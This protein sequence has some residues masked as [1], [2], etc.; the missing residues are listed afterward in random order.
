MP[1]VKQANA[2]EKPVDPS[3]DARNRRLRC[4]ACGREQAADAPAMPAGPAHPFDLVRCRFC[5]LVQ[6]H[7]R[8]SP[9]EIAALYGEDYY[10]FSEAEQH[11]WAR[12]TQQY[13]VHLLRFEPAGKRRLL[14]VGCAMGHL[15]ALAAERGWRVTGFD[16]S[17]SAVSQAQKRFNLDFRAGSL[18][19]LA[20]SL[21]PTD[22]VFLGD[23]IE[24]VL[25]PAA[26]LWQ[27]RRRLVSGGC[28]CIDTPIWGGRWRRF[29]GRHWSGL[30]RYHVNLFD[31]K[32]LGSLLEAGGFANIEMAAYTHHRYQSWADRPEI[33]AWVSKL[34]AALG[35]RIN[36]LLATIGA[37]GPWRELRSNP[38]TTLTE[39]TACV[40]RLATTAGASID[41]ASKADSLVA[42]ARR[43]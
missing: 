34:P 10:V 13:L 29:G 16:L 11:R 37:G 40:D 36:R 5:G 7:P 15:S 19:R 21:P 43:T 4:V 42:W 20:E 1:R 2:S 39:A 38:P 6:Q 24:H 35:W 23:V 31:A 33:Q 26:F 22:V 12:A 14:D 30:N 27:V 18:Q 8:Y 32:S 41:R 3:D 28:V 17:A 25:E 9:Q